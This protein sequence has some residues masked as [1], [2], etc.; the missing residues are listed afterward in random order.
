MYDRIL[1]PTDGDP[2]TERAVE[3]ALD[4]AGQYGADLHV[5]SVV[6]DAA[7]VSENAAVVAEALEQEGRNAVED[8][9]ERAEAAG[10][11]ATGTVQHGR[12]HRTI[13]DY[14][15]SNDVDLVVMGTHGRQGLDRYLLGSVAER[16]VRLSTVPV[17]TVR[18]SE[19]AVEST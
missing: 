9:A 3:H 6:D 2:R 17:L 4:L 15:E 10:V 19:D 14:T 18:M 11:A 5:L 13:L 16:V 12:P 1:L 8:I 7:L